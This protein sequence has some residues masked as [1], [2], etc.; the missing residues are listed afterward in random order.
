[1]SFWTDFAN[2]FGQ[3]VVM[4]AVA[5]AAFGMGGYWSQAII[6][7]TA[8]KL[9]KRFADPDLSDMY[10]G[11]VA[12]NERDVKI[13]EELAIVRELLGA[14]RTYVI[15]YHN[16]DKFISGS[17]VLRKSRTHESVAPGVA[18]TAHVISDVL[19]SRFAE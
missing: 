17:P 16:G 11:I 9:R 19:T 13:R 3:N 2:S 18:G 15:Q 10:G 14:S 4:P 12:F 8:R 1:M 6:H 7:A 5:S